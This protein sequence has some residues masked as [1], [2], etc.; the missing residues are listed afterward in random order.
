MSAVIRVVKVTP[1][2]TF[3]RLR[4]LHYQEKSDQIG[5]IP[6]MCSYEGQIIDWLGNWKPNRLL[7][8][9]ESLVWAL[10]ALPIKAGMKSNENGHV[11]GRLILTHAVFTKSLKKL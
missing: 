2:K 9:K 8:N 6:Y 3:W 7:G 11:I 10:P 5:K 4:K 1:K